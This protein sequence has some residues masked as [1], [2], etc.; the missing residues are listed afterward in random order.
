MIW[1]MSSLNLDTRSIGGAADLGGAADRHA[2]H[3][4]KN[5]AGHGFSLPSISKTILFA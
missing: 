5:D 2:R 3:A 4:N 1:H